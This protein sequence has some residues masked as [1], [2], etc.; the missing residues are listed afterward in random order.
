MNDDVSKVDVL[1]GK[2]IDARFVDRHDLFADGRAVPFVDEELA[3][4]DIPVKSVNDFQVGHCPVN[5]CMRL[6]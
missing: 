2:I 4:G 1:Y 5:R 6:T 3:G